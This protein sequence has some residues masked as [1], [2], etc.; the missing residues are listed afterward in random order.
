MGALP[1][2]PLFF[3]LWGRCPQAPAR[4][5]RPLDPVVGGGT[6]VFQTTVQTLQ[7]L[8]DVGGFWEYIGARRFCFREEIILL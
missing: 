5:R 6:G 2:S 3:G 4:E 1:P 8:A 7:G